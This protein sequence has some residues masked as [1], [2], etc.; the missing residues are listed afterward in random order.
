VADLGRPVKTGGRCLIRIP[1]IYEQRR[2]PTP[3]LCSTPR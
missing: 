3:T 2:F 1:T